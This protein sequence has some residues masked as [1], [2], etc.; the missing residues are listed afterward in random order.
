MELS[1]LEIQ[2]QKLN[3]MVL[4]THCIHHYLASIKD[5]VQ[6]CQEIVTRIKI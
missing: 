5:S 6:I 4:Q 2:L 3:N 1:N